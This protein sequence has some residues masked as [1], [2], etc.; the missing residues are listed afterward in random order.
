MGS[1][2]AGAARLTPSLF[3]LRVGGGAWR[4]ELK[5]YERCNRRNRH[6]PK[7]AAREASAQNFTSFTLELPPAEVVTWLGAIAERS[8]ST[9][10]ATLNSDDITESSARTPAKGRRR[11]DTRLGYSWAETQDSG[12]PGTARTCNPQI[13]S[14]MPRA[15]AVS[16]GN[17]SRRVKP[18]LFLVLIAM[19]GHCC[20]IGQQPLNAVGGL[21]PS[22]YPGTVR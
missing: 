5:I 12:A 20:L 17:S 19:V 6:P 15:N 3:G 14:L 21:I 8:R 9:P 18:P 4:C 13:R 2:P 10:S 16:Q 11:I 1:V 22:R 7:R